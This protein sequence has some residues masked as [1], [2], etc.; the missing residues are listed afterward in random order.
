MT[1]VNAIVWMEL[2]ELE[3]LPNGYELIVPHHWLPEDLRESHV[4]GILRDAYQESAGPSDEE[5]LELEIPY[6]T[7]EVAEFAP[8]MLVLQILQHASAGWV[9]NATFGLG[10]E[11][12][13]YS[14]MDEM[15]EMMPFLKPDAEIDTID[16]L[17]AAY[18]QW[19]GE[20]P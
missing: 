3:K 13:N 11:W 8:K 10:G 17:I 16:E 7:A 18:E 9:P 5:D 19:R 6:W 20:Q 15:F 12:V 4:T 2:D 14:V 1:K